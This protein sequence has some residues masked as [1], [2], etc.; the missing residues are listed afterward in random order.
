[1]LKIIFISLHKIC[2]GM[3]RNLGFLEIRFMMTI[4]PD[5]DT[6]VKLLYIL[7]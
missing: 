1:M 2:K 4:V 6:A 5:Q 7:K 3:E